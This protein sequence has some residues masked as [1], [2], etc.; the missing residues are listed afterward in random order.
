MAERRRKTDEEL[1]RTFWV[2]LESP[3]VI[4]IRFLSWEL[5]EENSTRQAELI[6]RAVYDIYAAN[7]GK[8]YHGLVD[9]LKVAGARYVSDGAKQ[10]YIQM[11]RRPELQRIAMVAEG[12][13]LRVLT[14]VM[15]Q[16]SSDWAN[17]KW[18]EDVEAARAWLAEVQLDK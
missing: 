3:D 13:F 2:G 11:M 4:I 17:V 12:T 14:G 6:Q 1:K 5:T 10:V 15:T 8:K 9:M 18:F 7:R 16:L